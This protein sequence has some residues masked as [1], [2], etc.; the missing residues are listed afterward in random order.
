[1]SRSF[2]ISA[3]YVS[4][5]QPGRYGRDFH[6]AII[7]S[8]RIEESAPADMAPD[9]NAVGRVIATFSEATG[10]PDIDIHDIDGAPA[11]Y[12]TF[13]RQITH[14]DIMVELVERCIDEA[15]MMAGRKLPPITG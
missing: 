13:R 2:N 5:N 14:E 8:G 4:E 9:S 7:G 1:M 6:D 15:L 11:D 10:L 3:P 12:W